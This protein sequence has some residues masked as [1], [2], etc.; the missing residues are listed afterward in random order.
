MSFRKGEVKK[1]KARGGK[2]PALPGLEPSPA[3][4]KMKE[5]SG[6]CT[7]SERTLETGE[8]FNPWVHGHLYWCSMFV[9][10]CEECKLSS[11]TH[12][13]DCSFWEKHPTITPF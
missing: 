12:K 1:A 5:Q 6:K 9:A 3:W 8:A 4:Q 11:G 10:Q 7:C 2:Q 13:L